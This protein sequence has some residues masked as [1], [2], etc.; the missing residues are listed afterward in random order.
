M[1]IPVLPRSIPTLKRFLFAAYIELNAI[2]TKIQPMYW[3]EQLSSLEGAVILLEDRRYFKHSGIDWK[4]SVR[5][6]WKMI[7]FRKFGG[8]STI[9]MQ[10]VRTCTGYKQKTLRRKCYEMFL[11]WALGHRATKLEILKAYLK[12]AY[13]GSGLI[14][15]ERT[16]GKVFGKSLGELTIE[17]I[18]FL[19]SMLVYPRPKIP[20]EKWRGKVIRRASYGIILL[21]KIGRSCLM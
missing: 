19:A 3:Q 17:E 16:S 7:T 21:K 4:S 13:F 15:V 1:T 9:E 10:F 8:S 5:D 2:E 14:G 18:Y 6:F 11:A 12:V 20:T